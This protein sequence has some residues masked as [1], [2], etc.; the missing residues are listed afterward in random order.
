MPNDPV[1]DEEV[2]AKFRQLSEPV[3]GKDRTERI[4]ETVMHL[5][6]LDDTNMLTQ[7]LSF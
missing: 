1:T 6:D 5:E 4:I 3:I 2:K 7:L